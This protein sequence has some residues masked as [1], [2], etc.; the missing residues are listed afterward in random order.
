MTSIY[1]SLPTG[2]NFDFLE[3][4]VVFTKLDIPL[5]LSSPGHGE[6]R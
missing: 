5:L 1:N 6:I 3:V 2:K 4:I